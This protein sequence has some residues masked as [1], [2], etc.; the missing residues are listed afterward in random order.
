MKPTLSV[1][2]ANQRSELTRLSDLVD[3]FAAVHHLLPDDVVTVHLVLD[4]M[5]SNIMRYGGDS[6]RPGVIGVLLTLD[7]RL[8]TIQLEDGGQPFNPLDY[9]AP[10]LDLPI[11]ERPLGGLGIYIV[12]AS[13]DEM[14]YRREGNRNV[15]TL[16]KTLG[17]PAGGP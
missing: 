8:L 17:G 9:P 2:L 11:E 5:V 14:A 6:G 16:R 3:G 4:E 1:T 10:D 13:V 12:R 7:D 15:L